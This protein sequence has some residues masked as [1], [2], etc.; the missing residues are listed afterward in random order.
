MEAVT[1][2]R[3]SL[4]SY[5]SVA[6]AV[7]LVIT[8]ITAMDNG[9]IGSNADSSSLLKLVAGGIVFA[10]FCAG[11]VWV[12]GQF[13]SENSKKDLDPEPGFFDEHQSNSSDEVE[14][15]SEETIQQI[16]EWLRADFE[17]A[18]TSCLNMISYQ[19]AIPEHEDKVVKIYE[20]L[21]NNNLQDAQTQARILLAAIG[22]KDP[23]NVTFIKDK[24]VTKGFDYTSLTYGDFL[25]QYTQ[26]DQ[27]CEMGYED[28]VG[29]LETDFSNQVQRQALQHR[30]TVEQ[31]LATQTD[32][33]AKVE[34]FYT[35]LLNNNFLGASATAKEI[36]RELE[37]EVKDLYQLYYHEQRG[38]STTNRR[39]IRVRTRNS[40][41][42]IDTSKFEGLTGGLQPRTVQNT[43][44][45]HSTEETSSQD[46]SAE[47]KKKPRRRI[48][49]KKGTYGTKDTSGQ[50]NKKK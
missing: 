29:F 9:S 48:K 20:Y 31:A 15:V 35:A 46:F 16:I 47:H 50:T 7:T 12:Y 23:N 49:R 33:L 6:L 40:V 39:T 19:P 4:F 27:E 1:M 41:G 21:Y 13:F 14:T 36:M 44:A 34:T 37:V 18:E 43:S 10:G 45:S 32:V 17:S 25:E 38:T 2:S 42:G 3:H 22:H 26:E 8:P 24:E 11:C 30:V 28:I 5:I